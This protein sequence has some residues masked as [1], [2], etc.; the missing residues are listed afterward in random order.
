M[1]RKYPRKNINEIVKHLFH[2][3]G[4][5]SPHIIYGGE[6][7]LDIRF[8]NDGLYGQGIYFANNSGYSFRYAHK[9]PNSSVNQMFVALVCTGDSTHERQ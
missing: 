9:V 1:I 4:K 2:G 6:D 3:C 8:S 5:T 7:G